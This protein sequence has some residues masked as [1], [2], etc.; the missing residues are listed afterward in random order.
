[1][2]LA[3]ERREI[4]RLEREMHQRLDLLA[5]GARREVREEMRRGR[6]VARCGLRCERR[7]VLRTTLDG[8]TSY[9]HGNIAQ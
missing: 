8:I 5:L 6:G 2:C 3:T 7:S 1:M 9:H 4:Q